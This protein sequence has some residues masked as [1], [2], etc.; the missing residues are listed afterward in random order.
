VE[1]GELHGLIE[2]IHSAP[3]AVVARLDAGAEFTSRLAVLPSAF[4]PPTRAHMELLQ[5]AL[6]AEGVGAIAA[7]LTTRNVAK[8]L[9]GASLAHR[10]SMLLEIES[11]GWDIP[12]LVANQARIADQAKLISAT[13]PAVGVDIIVG[14]DTLIRVFDAQY[15]G[16]M[17]TELQAFFADHRLIATN[18][19]DDAVDAVTRFLERPEVR[20]FASRIVVRELHDEAA[21]LSSTAAREAI[22]SGEDPF[23]LPAEVADYIHRHGLYRSEGA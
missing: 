21:D 11:A 23:H 2:R 14:Y 5:V 20:P 10:A 16:E 4:N 7:L 12:V 19:A 15:Y 8:E 13:W 1:H 6:G 18:R 22:A 3:D 17:E 9:H